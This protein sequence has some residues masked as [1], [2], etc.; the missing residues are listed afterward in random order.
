MKKIIFIAFLWL[1][2]IGYAQDN[3]IV[4]T[5]DGRRVLLKA[6]YTWEYID[7][8]PQQNQPKPNVV[9]Q[10]RVQ[11]RTR[12]VQ[13]PA[14]VLEPVLVSK[15]CNAG[16]GFSE[17]KLDRRIQTQLKK[18]RATMK[19]LKKRVA[20]TYSCSVADVLLLYAKETKANG[21]YTFCANGEKVTYKRTGSNFF[22]KG[23]FF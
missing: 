5:E 7:L 13:A 22:R 1:S 16:P 20:K 10:P 21:V 19:D 3:Y 14:P 15:N 6:D 17:P 12:P 23:K 18:G 9:P 4:T 8:V 11:E 2:F